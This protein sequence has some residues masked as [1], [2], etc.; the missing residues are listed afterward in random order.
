M[1]II[2]ACGG[3]AGHINPAIT[4]AK[5]FLKNE[6][7]TKILFVGAKNGME[8]NLVKSAGFDFRSTTISGFNRKLNFSAFLHNLKTFR[9]IFVAKRESEKILSEFKPDICMGTGGYATGPFLKQAHKMGIPYVIHEQNVF[10]GIT[11]KLLAKNAAKVLLAADGAKKFLNKNTNFL[12]VGNPIRVEFVNKDQNEAKKSLGFDEKP[13]ILSF[14]GSLGA[15]IINKSI[16]GLI[17]ENFRNYN[18]IH[19]HGKNCKNFLDLLNKNIK[20]NSNNLVIKDYIENMP[21]CLLA[22]N[23]VICRAGAITLSEICAYQKP[24]ILIPS[25]NV[26]ENHQF[27]NA[28]DLVNANAASM[29]EEKNLHKN[30]LIKEVNLLINDKNK[31]NTYKNNLKKLSILNA[32]ERIYDAI[33][34]VVSH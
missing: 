15:E 6:P 8:E 29:I 34:L 12:T 33:K 13:L 26:A 2:F 10:P 14:G 27:H 16:A 23:L 21:T 32:D 25:P 17:N 5:C 20:K 24:A 7:Q 30:S 28:M 22:A 9:N 11:T 19:A 18:F 3:T 31:V 4:V 1:K